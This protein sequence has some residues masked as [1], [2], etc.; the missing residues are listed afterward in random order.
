M[1]NI[2]QH[3]ETNRKFYF[4]HICRTC[5]LHVMFYLPDVA[6][7]KK[8]MI[9]N[10]RKTCNGLRVFSLLILFSPRYVLEYKHG[11]YT[12]YIALS[13]LCMISGS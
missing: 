7:R 13:V 2:L 4:L 12:L 11:S 3:N 10:L 5:G 1:H 8:N 9:N 6:C